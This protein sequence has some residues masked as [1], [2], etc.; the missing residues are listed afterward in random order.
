MKKPPTPIVCIAFSRSSNELRHSRLTDLAE[1]CF[2]FT[3]EVSIREGEALFL[4]MTRS[5]HLFQPHLLALKFQALCRRF[6]LPTP[7]IT[8][9]FSARWALVLAKYLPN[10]THPTTSPNDTNSELLPLLPVEAIE[11]L[12]N[13][14]SKLTP[15]AQLSKHLAIFHKLGIHTL[16]D[17]QQLPTLELV[18]RLGP[19]GRLI[20]SSLLDSIEPIWPTHKPPEIFETTQSLLD[21]ETCGSLCAHQSEALLFAIKHS[22][23]QL[24]AKLH[25]R[26]LL[27][28]ELSLTLDGKQARTINFEFSQPT[29]SIK[30][31][32]FLIREQL[33][34]K[35]EQEPPQK[36]HNEAPNDSL[37]SLHLK[38]L[39]TRPS[40]SR[41]QFIFD[42]NLAQTES[43]ETLVNRIDAKIEKNRIFK[44]RLND[45]YLPEKNF[46]HESIH[47]NDAHEKIRDTPKSSIS[48]L[49]FPYRPTILLNP[50]LAIKKH[51]AFLYINPNINPNITPNTNLNADPRHPKSSL[52]QRLNLPV[53]LF[54]IQSTPLERIR[55]T[56]W[57]HHAEIIHSNDREYF[58]VHATQANL[59]PV[60]LVSPPTSINP[61]N[62]FPLYK[63][64]ILLTD[65][66]YFIHGVFD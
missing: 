3:P 47:A 21:P 55:N 8:H 51:G 19:L 56:H 4:N 34:R 31:L 20:Q 58:E 43:L 14:F 46:V 65:Q 39:R 38:V 27:V 32:I 15:E 30:S 9:A 16:E 49:D 64:W 10:H 24:I 63:L 11:D 25:A 36:E 18:T 26:H 12:I 61:S 2:R 37:E 35:L 29:N 1:S 66:R 13:P 33:N 42:N 28:S 52:H 45:E 57:I 60:T 40:R 62:G 50:P 7:I 54:I 5:Y 6:E 53:Q 17:L 41:Q 48:H 22:L 59:S 23:D 44:I